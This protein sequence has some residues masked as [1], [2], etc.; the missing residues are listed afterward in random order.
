MSE[1]FSIDL[2]AVRAYQARKRALREA[3]L[4]ARFERAG[5]DFARIVARIIERHSPQRVWQWGSLLDRGKWS[6]ISDIDI[7]V[8]GLAGAE[9]WF[10]LLGD[11]MGMTDFP[12]DIVE[13]EH[14]QAPNADYIRRC[15]RLIYERER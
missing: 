15:G 12:L 7:A 5:E 3:E 2:D 6:E 8:E 13:L 11:V 10:A 1:D 14:V 9:A 4:D